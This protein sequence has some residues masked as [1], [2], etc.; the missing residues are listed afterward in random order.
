MQNRNLTHSTH[1]SGCAYCAVSRDVMKADIELDN[2]KP[3]VKCCDMYEVYKAL[4]SLRG[5]HFFDGNQSDQDGE[6]LI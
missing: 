1:I 3:E 4:R 2:A 5:D 6:Q